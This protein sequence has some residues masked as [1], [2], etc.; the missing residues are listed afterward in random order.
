M[1]S[2]KLPSYDEVMNPATN[3]VIF[4]GGQAAKIPKPEML[5]LIPPAFSAVT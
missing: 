2:D 5:Y 1:G 4:R 3:P